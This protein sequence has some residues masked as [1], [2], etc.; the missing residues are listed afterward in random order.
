[1]RS[2]DALARAIALAAL[3]GVAAC[4]GGS[5]VVGNPGSAGSGTPVATAMD[6]AA[7]VAGHPIVLEVDSAITSSRP[8]DDVDHMMAGAAETVARD[9]SR[10]RAQE[11]DV[12][13][14]EVPRLARIACRYGDGGDHEVRWEGTTLVI[15]RKYRWQVLASGDVAGALRDDYYGALARRF[16]H[17]EPEQVAPADRGDYFAYVVRG[18]AG[19]DDDDSRRRPV[20][21]A[22]VA[23][24]LRLSAASGGADARLADRM[25]AWLLARAREMADADPSAA[26]AESKQTHAAWVR[27][28]DATLP[29][30][31]AAEKLAVAVAVFADRS[32]YGYRTPRFAGDSLQGFDVFAFGLSIADAWVASGHPTEVVDDPP[33]HLWHLIL[34]P[35]PLDSFGALPR[36]NYGSSPWLLS[37]FQADPEGRRLADAL[38]ARNDPGLVGAVIYGLPSSDRVGGDPKG[39]TPRDR[40]LQQLERYP[41]TW[42][43]AM[44]MLIGQGM[45]YEGCDQSLVDEANR[46]WHTAPALRGTALHV[47]ACKEGRTRSGADWFFPQFSH[48]YGESVGATLF[49]AFLDDGPDAMRLA[50]GLWPAMSPGWSRAA[51]I[52]PRL[53]AFL[54]DP[55]VR[56]G[57][58]GEPMRTLGALAKRLCEDGPAEV[59]RL[60]DELATRARRDVAEARALAKVLDDTAAGRCSPPP[61]PASAS[62]PA[63]KRRRR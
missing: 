51:A 25:R 1:V 57:E 59:A 4:G 32:S 37:A 15:T 39:P 3:V 45:A 58:D 53:D 34:D 23:R 55:R 21:D 48:L 11:P 31:S 43:L 56:A 10:L 40:L 30:A 49:G 44:G 18:E 19:D 50:E 24:V 35:P 6:R 29:T 61:P 20:P 28:L 54:A 9:L 14:A 38:A 41:K 13:A 22:V 52:A 60:H 42:R 47:I 27:W 12:F 8:S 7:S 46:V 16:E 2:A 17:V 5:T 26:T 36:F 62:A 63:S 33:H